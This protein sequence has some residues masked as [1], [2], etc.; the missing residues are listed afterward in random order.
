MVFSELHVIFG[1][2]LGGSE[3]R[4]STI[5]CY[6]MFLAVVLLELLTA[7]HFCAGEEW[8]I[9][10]KADWGTRECRRWEADLR[11]SLSNNRNARSHWLSHL[12]QETS[13]PN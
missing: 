12:R 4:V 10:R 9:C 2:A 5:G 11:C 8:T 7:A 13:E 3:E 1:V 6:F